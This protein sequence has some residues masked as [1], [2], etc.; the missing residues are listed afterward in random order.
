MR[1]IVRV[2]RWSPISVSAQITISRHP[3]DH[4]VVGQDHLF[5]ARD[6]QGPLIVDVRVEALEAVRARCAETKQDWHDA[7]ARLA[8]RKGCWIDPAS[9]VRYLHLRSA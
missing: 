4:Q 6:G 5:Q 9:P 2:P 1:R 8:E 3:Q 7:I